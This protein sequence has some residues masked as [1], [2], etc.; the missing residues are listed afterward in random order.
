MVSIPAYFAAKGR[1]KLPFFVNLLFG[2]RASVQARFPEIGT[3]ISALP[4]GSL[5][6]LAEIGAA[7]PGLRIGMAFSATRGPHAAVT[8]PALPFSF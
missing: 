3:L 6:S 7:V 8:K 4:A 1:L 5:Y 2:N